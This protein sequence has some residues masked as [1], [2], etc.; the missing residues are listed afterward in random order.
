MRLWPY[1]K[2]SHRG[3]LDNVRRASA[4]AN[5]LAEFNPT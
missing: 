4:I 2:S 3:S 5:I 1:A